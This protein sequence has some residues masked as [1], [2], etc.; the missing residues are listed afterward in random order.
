[1]SSGETPGRQDPARPRRAGC[2]CPR[3]WHDR[4]R[5]ER[6]AVPGDE[7]GAPRWSRPATARGRSRCRRPAPEGAHGRSRRRRAR[8]KLRLGSGEQSAGGCRRRTWPSPPRP[9][10]PTPTPTPTP[11]PKAFTDAG[12]EQPRRRGGLPRAGSRA[13]RRGRHRDDTGRSY[14]PTTGKFTGRAPTRAAVMHTATPP[15]RPRPDPGGERRHR[16]AAAA[17]RAT[18]MFQPRPPD[19]GPTRDAG[20]AAGGRSCR[21]GT[22]PSTSR[23]LSCMTRARASSR[24]RRHDD[25]TRRSRGAPAGRR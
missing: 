21:C 20:P 24:P 7:P 14:D 3:G 4:V 25:R 2:R 22:R 6:R 8:R 15:P 23:Q 17:A 9:A 11:K 19:G 16:A 12:G 18:G 13:C 10:R 1:M 5:T